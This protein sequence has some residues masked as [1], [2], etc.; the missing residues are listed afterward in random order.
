MNL[1]PYLRATAIGSIAGLRTFS[2]PTATL[3]ANHSGWAR[4]SLLLALGEL[5]ADKLP[6]TPSRVSALPLLARA[7]SGGWS[8]RVVARQRGGSALLGAA[9]GATGAVGGA[10]VGYRLRSFLT[11]RLGLPDAPVALIEDAVAI[12]GLLTITRGNP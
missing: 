12:M 10:W 6:A 2:A 3:F 9:L 7:V 8:G 11:Q 5:V 4:P 1:E